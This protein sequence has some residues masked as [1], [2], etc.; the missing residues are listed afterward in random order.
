LAHGAID[1]EPPANNGRLASALDARPAQEGAAAPRRRR[2]AE[3]GAYVASRLRELRQAR[4]MTQ[5]ELAALLGVKRE[6]ISRYES[7]A[8]AVTVALLLDIAIALGQPLEAFLPP[9]RPPNRISQVQE[10]LVAPREELH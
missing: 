1:V 3:V 5:G 6:S 7:G 2:E 4:A 10:P 8:R 9:A